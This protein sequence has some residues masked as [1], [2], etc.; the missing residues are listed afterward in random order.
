MR[1]DIQNSKLIHCM[2]ASA[3]LIDGL[4]SSMRFDL[5]FI[6]WLAWYAAT[7]A[8]FPIWSVVVTRNKM[9]NGGKNES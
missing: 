8:I 2:N 6:Q 5:N 9:F 7:N 1:I 3:E 4:V